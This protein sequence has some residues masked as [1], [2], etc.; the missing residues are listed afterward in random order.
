MATPT[1]GKPDYKASE[2]AKIHIAKKELGMDVDTY[3]DM[4]MQIA[5]VSSA[6]DLSAT[7]RAKVLEYL[8]SKGFKGK[9]T[10]NK[11]PHTA[12][13]KA[14]I[15]K[16]EAQLADM[17][18]PWD[19]LIARQQGKVGKTLSMLERL[20]G[21]KRLEWCTKADLSKVIAALANHQKKLNE[22]K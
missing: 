10:Y 6:A 22:G 11:R 7:G 14:Q 12:D 4:L 18:L 1:K 9:K 17:Q 13:N 20:T 3:R 2:L 5:K 8:K 19:Y 21:K 15:L 16:I